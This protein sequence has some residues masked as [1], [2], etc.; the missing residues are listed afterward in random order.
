MQEGGRLFSTM[1]VCFDYFRV[2]STS[3]IL[4]IVFGG[5]GL[6]IA[7]QL[8]WWCFVAR[9]LCGA[10]RLTT[11][12]SCVPYSPRAGFGCACEHLQLFRRTVRF[13]LLKNCCGNKPVHALV[14]VL[15]I[16]TYYN[17]KGHAVLYR[18][19]PQP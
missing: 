4:S 1:S 15:V 17:P 16:R 2:R 13:V 11:L 7:R 19:N 8:M 10:P 6:S 9:E 18:S 5:W 14:V 12:Q 3:H